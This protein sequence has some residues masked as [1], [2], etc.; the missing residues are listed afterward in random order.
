VENYSQLEYITAIWYTLRPFG[1]SVVIWYIFPPFWYIVSR[2]IWQPCT[3][4]ENDAGIFV[5][6]KQG[7]QTYIQT[8]NPNLGL[9][10]RTWNGKCEYIYGHLV[11]FVAIWC[12][13]R[14]FGIVCDH[15]VYFMAIWHIL[16]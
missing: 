1:P 10:R 2:K 4:L 8:E 5:L 13:S 9:F 7:C 14:Q 16:W 15:L 3:R 11:Y 12:I 6:H